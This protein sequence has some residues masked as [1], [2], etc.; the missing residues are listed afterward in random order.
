MDVVVVGGL[1]RPAG[2]G[3]AARGRGPGHPHHREGRRLR[4]HLVLEPLSRAWRRG[5]PTSICRCWKRSATC[6]WRNTPGL[7]ILAHSRAIGRHFDLY[8]TF[9]SKFLNIGKLDQAASTAMLKRSLDAGISFFDTSVCSYGESETC[10]VT[11]L[12]TGLRRDAYVIATKVFGNMSPQATPARSASKPKPR[13]VAAPH[14]GELR[15]QLEAPRHRLHR[16]LPGARLGSGDADGR[17][18]ARA[19]RP[20]PPRAKS[21]TS[22]ARTG[23]DATWR[24]R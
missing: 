3:P 15:E 5:V 23:R 13:L 6:W 14:H 22:V 19:R 24:R 18:A 8:Q 10:S 1:W 4:R 2:R 20:R 16:P 21:A 11:R 12:K 7:E 17:D 9:G